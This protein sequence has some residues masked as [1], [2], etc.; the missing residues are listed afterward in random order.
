VL[1]ASYDTV[2]A[3]RAFAEKFRYP[4]RLLCDVDRSLGAAYEADDPDDPGYPR[5][6]SYLIGP[7]RRIV[8]AY[9]PVFVGTH[10]ADVIAD[11]G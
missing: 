3:N 8:K 11:V 9:D 1:G 2:D 7:D 4:F 6:I 10:A 5:R